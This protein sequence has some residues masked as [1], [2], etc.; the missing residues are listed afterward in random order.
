MQSGVRS[1]AEEHGH[2]TAPGRPPLCVGPPHGRVLHPPDLRTVPELAASMRIQEEYISIVEPYS[3]H[4]IAGRPCPEGRRRQQAD[5]PC[6]PCAMQALPRR[7]VMAMLLSCLP[8][9]TNEAGTYIDRHVLTYYCCYLS[10]MLQC[11]VR[12]MPRLGY[13]R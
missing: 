8:A 5:V 1:A 2:S 3:N 9:S 7:A 13:N 4:R 11:H 6:R 12:S 10:Y